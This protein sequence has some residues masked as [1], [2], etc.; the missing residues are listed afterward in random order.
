MRVVTGSLW[1]ACYGTT[2]STQMVEV[3]NPA[4]KG[5]S[6]PEVREAQSSGITVKLLEYAGG[7]LFELDVK[8][9]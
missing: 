7:G 2:Q 9:S 1:R 6:Q 5:A 3:D 4:P 8:T